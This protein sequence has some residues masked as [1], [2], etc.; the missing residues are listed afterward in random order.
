MAVSPRMSCFGAL[1]SVPWAILEKYRT[2][3]YS[4]SLPCLSF[5]PETWIWWWMLNWKRCFRIMN[6]TPIMYKTRLKLTE[7]TRN[8]GTKDVF[9]RPADFCKLILDSCFDILKMVVSTKLSTCKECQQMFVKILHFGQRSQV[10]MGLLGCP[11]Q[12]QELDYT[13]KRLFSGTEN[14]RWPFCPFK[15]FLWKG[16]FSALLKYWETW[17]TPELFPSQLNSS[18]KQWLPLMLHMCDQKKLSC[19]KPNITHTH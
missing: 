17:L 14:A 3:L 1:T 6:L 15:K 11:V 10:C 5:S 16:L 12:A 8:R 7:T 2:I 18:T 9:L 13:S 19:P 4:P